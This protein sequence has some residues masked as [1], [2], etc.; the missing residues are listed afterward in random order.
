MTTFWTLLVLLLVKR[1]GMLLLLLLLLLV[2]V[3]VVAV[4]LS[5]PSAFVLNRLRPS[6]TAVCAL[7]A[8]PLPLLP[9]LLPCLWSSAPRPLFY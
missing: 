9:C 2:V 7:A 6:W 5:F 8:A 3:V 1:N 4:L